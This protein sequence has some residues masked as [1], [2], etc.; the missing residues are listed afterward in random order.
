MGFIQ[1]IEFHGDQAEFERML[2]KYRERMGTETTARRA[3]L[4][5][6]R[7]LDGT[8]IQLVEFDSYEEAMKNSD[9]PGTQQWAA[10]AAELMQD[11]VFRNLE[12]VATY[13]M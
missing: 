1:L 13:T 2:E 10:E 5:R 11:A 3:T 6:D 7:E 9:H 8:L 12:V 4:L